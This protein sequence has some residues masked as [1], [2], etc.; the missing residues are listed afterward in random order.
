MKSLILFLFS[1]IIHSLNSNH[2][3][4]II[5]GVIYCIVASQ[6]ENELKE[7][8]SSKYS[9]PDFFLSKTSIYIYMRRK[10]DGEFY[11][12]D[13]GDKRAVKETYLWVNTPSCRSPLDKKK[14]CRTTIRISPV[15]SSTESPFSPILIV[16]GA[17]NSATKTVCE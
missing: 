16:L 3:K 9:N 11:L 15:Q 5:S 2:Q 12:L 8:R 7:Y 6:N 10:W 4:G 13:K 17:S 14:K 1:L